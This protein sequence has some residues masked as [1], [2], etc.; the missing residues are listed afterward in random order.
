MQLQIGTTLQG[1]KYR[2]TEVLGQGGFGITYL[3]EQP[4]MLNRKVAIKEFFLKEYFTRDVTTAHVTCSTKST[5]AMA[6]TY[7][8]KFIKEAQLQLQ[9]RHPNLVDIYDIFEENDTAYYVM[10]Y[11]EGETLADIV[12]RRGALPK[13]EAV[14]YIRKVAEALKY[15]HTHHVTHLDVKPANILIR[16]SDG[17]V[18]LIDFGTSKHY[19]SKS[20]EQTTIATP[21]YSPGYA[22]IE[23]YNTGGIFSFTPQADIYAL[24]A[25]FYK[26]ITGQTP[27]EPGEIANEGL[28]E[29]SR[30]PLSFGMAIG[31][32]MSLKKDDRPSLETFLSYIDGKETDSQLPPSLNSE[33]EETKIIQQPKL[34]DAS[35]RND[36][37]DNIKPKYID[38]D[39]PYDNTGW[40][41]DITSM[42]GRWRRREFASLV[43][44]CLIVSYVPIIGTIV[45]VVL[46]LAISAKR[47]HDIGVSSKWL[48]ILLVLI[49]I[50]SIMAMIPSDYSLLCLIPVV[51]C[52]LLLL[53]YPGTD[54]LNAYG[55]DPRRDYEEQCMEAGYPKLSECFAAE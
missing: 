55:S 14:G 4:L 3:A 25:T 42:N 17:C 19:D 5:R 21:C 27:P 13:E 51:I 10:E 45:S 22:P 26:L 39:W 46:F 28:P 2:I 29:I 53:F 49:V 18:K 54:G 34:N 37:E 35:A 11:V 33:D 9:M 31:K 20:G 24:G 41:Q 23:Q 6:D 12:K 15:I 40:Y 30:V 16:K 50:Y 44:V 8:R 32:A 7:R 52:V 38:Y 48:C 36:V 43:P 1:G 47:I